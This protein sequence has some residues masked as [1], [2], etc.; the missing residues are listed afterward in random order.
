MAI[1]VL[2]TSLIGHSFLLSHKN[3]GFNIYIFVG[4]P[5]DLDFKSKGYLV[6]SKF[7]WTSVGTAPTTQI[8]N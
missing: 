6:L 1:Y 8:L 5:A 2:Y 3:V 4:K 7:E